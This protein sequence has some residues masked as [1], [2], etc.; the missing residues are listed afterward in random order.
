MNELL[1][2]AH[3]AVVLSFTLLALYIGKES[4]VALV[5][6]SGI[7]ANLFV[8]K[9]VNLFGLT[10]TASDAYMIAGILGLNL[11]QEYY[12]KV[13]AK[14]A[15][16][17]SLCMN[18]FYLIISQLHLMLLPSIGDTGHMHYKALLSPMPRIVGASIVVY[19]FVQCIDYFLYQFLRT[20]FAQKNL[21]LVFLH[22]GFH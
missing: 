9:Q 5:G 16:L 7:L 20:S 1:F 2:F 19:F 11:L 3:V 10:V 17:V 22:G 12:G 13:V 15:I 14:R 8:L 18:L 6:V 4:L 21:V